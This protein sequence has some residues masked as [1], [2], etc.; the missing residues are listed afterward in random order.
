MV[1]KL[2]T[3]SGGFSEKQGKNKMIPN[4]G[5]RRQENERRMILRRI[6]SRSGRIGN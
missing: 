3:P 5:A 4:K 2:K 6:T 1:K